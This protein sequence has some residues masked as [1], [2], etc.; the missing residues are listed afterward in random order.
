ML[1][2]GKSVLYG[3]LHDVINA[4]SEDLYQLEV[5]GDIYKNEKL[6]SFE[7]VDSKIMLRPKEGVKIEEI[8]KKLINDGVHLK[9]FSRKY[10]SL[11]EIFISAVK[12]S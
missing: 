4:H 5:D 7:H 2:K 12:N 6:Y 3:N 8:I 11:E 10:K 9:S 1:N